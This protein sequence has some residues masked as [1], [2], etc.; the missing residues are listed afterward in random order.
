MPSS[1]QPPIP[2][3]SSSPSHSNRRRQPEA[4][5]ARGE[6]WG[7]G[8]VGK[9]CKDCCRLFTG[10]AYSSCII[11]QFWASFRTTKHAFYFTRKWNS[12]PVFTSLSVSFSLRRQMLHTAHMFLHCKF[13]DK[14]NRFY[15]HHA[16]S[17]GV[18]YKLH[19]TTFRFCD[20]ISGIDIKWPPCRTTG[21]I[22]FEMFFPIWPCRITRL[23]KDGKGTL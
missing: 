10:S 3:C 9:N 6:G 19:L 22:K 5:R 8:E 2:H 11:L 17:K 21:P 18:L 13:S 16:Q 15:K 14:K 23:K 12:L 20:Y 4:R 7:G 1:R